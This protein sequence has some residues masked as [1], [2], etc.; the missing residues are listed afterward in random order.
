MRHPSPR[1]ITDLTIPELDGASPG[2]F[3]FSPD[4]R[5]FYILAGTASTVKRDHLF[6]FDSTN[7]PA[8]TLLQEIGLISTANSAHSFD[9]LVQPP[10]GSPAGTLAEAKYLVVSNGA[11]NTVSIINATDYLIKQ[12]VTVG[13]NPGAVMVYY[14]GAAAG[15]HQATASL[16]G[17]SS[18][19]V[20]GL[21]ERLDDHGMPE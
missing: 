2:A 17:G 21:P 20:A 1:T 14:P 9:V 5:R 4:G 10:T 13:I 6:A 7:L 12:T 18:S 19:P 16:T 11:A 15:G 3:K 8:L